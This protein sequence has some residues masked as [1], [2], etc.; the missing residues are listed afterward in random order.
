MLDL[1]Q[2]TKDQ[3][4]QNREDDRCHDGEIDTDISVWTLVFN[5]TWQKRQSGSDVGPVGSCA[6]VSQPA[7]ERKNKQH[8]EEDFQKHIHDTVGKL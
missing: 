2:E 7:D 1:A 8:D 4:K 5:I 6:A 3:S